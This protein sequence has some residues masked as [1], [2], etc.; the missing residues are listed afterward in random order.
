MAAGTNTR[1]RTGLEQFYT[2]AASR[3]EIQA[4]TWWDF[5]EPC[6]SRQRQRCSYENENPRESYS[7]LLALKNRIIRKA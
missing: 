2:I 7:G 3:R 5:I 4:L 6:F 1:R